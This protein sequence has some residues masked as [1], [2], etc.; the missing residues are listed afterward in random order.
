VEI[1]DSAKRLLR[2][3]DRT[4]PQFKSRF[5]E[6]IRRIRRNDVIRQVQASLEAGNIE[7]ALVQAEQASV[8]L[9]RLWGQIFVLSAGE[10]A[11]FLNRF[12]EF[13]V[14]YDISNFRAVEQIR[15]NQFR[16]IRDFNIQQRAAVQEAL[17]SS[18]ERGVNPRQTAREFVASIGLTEHQVRAVNRFRTLLQENSRDALTRQLRDRRFDPSIRRAIRT[19]EVLNAATIDRMVDRYRE[20]FIAFRAEGIAR[21]EA[22]AAVNAGSEEMYSQLIDQG[23]IDPLDM[24][25]I[26][27]PSNDERTRT[28]HRSMEGQRRG[29]GQ[30]FVS[31]NGFNLRYPGDPRA[32]AEERIKCRCAI[33]TRIRIP[34][35]IS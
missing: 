29:F 4:A 9:S 16:L 35:T 30:P 11:D 31:G 26:W 24:D 15:E 5:L 20:R 32:P 28:S 2:V 18:L 6:A 25:R 3:V 21:T 10:T 17:I 12:L 7:R 8:A 13:N 1:E 34:E 33:L 14:A 23:L 27:D 19:G 22:L